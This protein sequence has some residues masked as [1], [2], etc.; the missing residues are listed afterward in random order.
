MARTKNTHRVHHT[1]SRTKLMVHET[2]GERQ[3]PTYVKLTKSKR[4]D[5]RCKA[6][7]E[8]LQTIE[9]H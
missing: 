1:Q 2:L 5:R 6:T 9:V 7:R 4:P 8:F 3:V